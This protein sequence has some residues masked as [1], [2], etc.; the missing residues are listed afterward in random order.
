[1]APA[2]RGRISSP[3]ARRLGEGRLGA[4]ATENLGQAQPELLVDHDD[5]AT[6]NR[7]AVDEQIDGFAGHAVEGHDRPLPQLERL[8]DGESRPADLN[9]QVDRHVAQ[10]AQVLEGALGAAD[11]R[12]GFQLFEWSL[13]PTRCFLTGPPGP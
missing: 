13:D 5:L 9:R 4:R 11:L 12:R 7:G 3:P 8:P 10:P 2:G 6:C 1:M